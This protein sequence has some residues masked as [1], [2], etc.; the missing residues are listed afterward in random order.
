MRGRPKE[1]IIVEKPIKFE[2]RYSDKDGIISVWK[3]D[4]SKTTN[5][6]ISVELIY[7][8][9]YSTQTKEQDY[10]KKYKNAPLT[11]RKWI[12][13]KNGKEVSY[14]RARQLGLIK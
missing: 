13:P 10:D 1:N 2:K 8:K 12:N 7:P 6:P 5:G 11:Q 9:S 4:L 3:Y 14:Q